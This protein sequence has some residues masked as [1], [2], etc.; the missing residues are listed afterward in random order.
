MRENCPQARRIM[1]AK[2]P[3]KWHV[4]VFVLILLFAGP[5]ARSANIVLVS[6]N[7]PDTAHDNLWLPAI[8][9]YPDDFYV[10]MMQAAGHNVIRFNPPAS[11]NTL[12][13][14]AQLT[15][16][17]TND[18]IFVGRSI[19]S[20]EFQAPQ[21]SNWNAR[22]TKPL[23][24]TSP[25]LVR[26]DGNRLSWFVNGNGVLPDT[27]PPTRIKAMD[28][29]DPETAFLFQDVDMNGDTMANSFDEPLERNTSTIT[30]GPVA[31]GKQLGTVLLGAQTGN[32]ITE[33][34]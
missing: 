8:A 27:T 12:L 20:G 19:N 3:L 1:N 25:Y 9:G 10:Q 22:I 21:S 18:L 17:N 2:N 11:Q 13:T 24:M 29:S 15:A 33:F 14:A 28:L 7:P 26:Q 30:N 6:D 23:I 31:G 34:P 5:A 16:L 4:S 32:I